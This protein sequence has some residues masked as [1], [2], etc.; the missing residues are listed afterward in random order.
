[1]QKAFVIQIPKAP[2]TLQTVPIPK[3]GPDKLL[4]KVIAVGLNPAD[5]FV[6][7]NAPTFMELNYP[8]IMGYD[9]AGDAV[10]VGESVTGFEKGDRV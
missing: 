8:L 2:L 6:H 10:E 1:M 7:S 4:V 9:L 5:E 3:P